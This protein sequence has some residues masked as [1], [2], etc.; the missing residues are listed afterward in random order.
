MITYLFVDSA[1]ESCNSVYVI[2]QQ[3][4]KKTFTIHQVSNF[5]SMPRLASLSQHLIPLLSG[6]CSLGLYER[7]PE[8]E[9][10]V[11]GSGDGGSS[12]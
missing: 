2:F 8:G 9:E 5:T 6:S 11:R 1:F 3:S 4:W 7:V 10:W 12:K